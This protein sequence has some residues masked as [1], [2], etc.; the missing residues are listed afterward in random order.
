MATGHKTGGRV[1]GTLNKR[2]AKQKAASRAVIAQFEAAVPSAFD[3]DAVS[4]LQLVYRNPAM[5]WEIRIDC[6]KA[7]CRFER[8]QLSAVATRDVTPTPATQADANRRIQEQ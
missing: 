5:P 7:A 4:L 1:K 6:A 3:G 8:P 2:T